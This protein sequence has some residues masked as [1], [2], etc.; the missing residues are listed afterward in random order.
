MGDRLVFLLLC[1]V[2]AGWQVRAGEWNTY[3]G[4]TDLRGVSSGRVKGTPVRLWRTRVGRD[5]P[6]SVVAGGGRI[7][8]VPDN[9]TVTALDAKGA[10]LWGGTISS[11]EGKN[12]GETGHETFL[13]PLL[14]TGSRLIVAAESGRVYS[15]SPK[16]GQKTWVYAAG[17]QI[18]G[19]PNFSV[20]DGKDPD[21]LIVMTGE[22]GVV[23]GVDLSNGQRLWMSRPTERCD[24]HVAVAGE[25]VVFGNCVAAIFS[26]SVKTG[27]TLSKIELG[28]GHEMAGGTALWGGKAFGGTRSGALACADLAAGTLL[29]MREDTAGELFTTPAVTAEKVVYIGGDGVVRCVLHET[30]EEA[31]S[32]NTGGR[33]AMSPVIAG[34]T[35]IAPVDG[36]LYGLSLQDGA[37]RWTVSIGDEITAPS[38]VDGM[39]V[40]GVDDGYVAAYGAAGKEP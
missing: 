31:W 3:H 30:N 16:D 8:C 35:V 24:G 22:E 10:I 37:L 29:W 17:G 25:R 11:P 20:G 13:A 7:F 39:I 18:R 2:L 5:L 15:L 21:R 38:I 19:T 4:G 27:K 34:D 32:Y 33:R 1:V 36:S 40:V 14:Y 12:G 26:L 9:T 6:L 28:K 23:H